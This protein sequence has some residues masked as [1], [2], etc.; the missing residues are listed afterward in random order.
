MVL[1]ATK[2]Q[3]YIN[4]CLE[5]YY[6]DLH[7]LVYRCNNSYYNNTYPFHSL[8]LKLLNKGMK[9]YSKMILFILFHS[10]LFPPP[11]QI[12]RFQVLRMLRDKICF[13]CRDVYISNNG[14]AL[15]HQCDRH[16]S[17][18]KNCD[19][20]GRPEVDHLNSTLTCRRCK[21][22]FDL[23]SEPAMPVNLVI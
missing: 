21:N 11:K 23:E 13:D 7:Q 10:I 8:P 3:C 15:C 18:C 20:F 19:S 9:E 16:I 14:V 12:L 2:I 5:I 4:H 1:I 6:N 22:S 17:Y